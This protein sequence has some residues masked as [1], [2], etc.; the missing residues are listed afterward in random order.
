MKW[1][2]LDIVTVSR[3][4]DPSMDGDSPLEPQLMHV[5]AARAGFLSCLLG[6][7]VI[8]L[9]KP[10]AHEIRETKDSKAC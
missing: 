7:V 6:L 4:L 1:T 2:H 10:T 3:C 5:D 9:A 8:S